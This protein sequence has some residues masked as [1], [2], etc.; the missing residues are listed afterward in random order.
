MKLGTWLLAL[1]QPMLGKILASLGF[2][3]VTI[4]GVNVVVGQLKQQAISGFALLS[5]EMLNLFLLAGGGTGLGIILGACATKLLLWQLES[6]TRIL[7]S[8]PG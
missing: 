2:S 3:V 6:A 7:G 8:N 5:P 1:V 4:T